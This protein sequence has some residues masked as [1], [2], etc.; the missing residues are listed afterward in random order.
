MD[1]K[2]LAYINMYAV[3]GGLVKLCDMV[4][5]AQK[6]LGKSGASIG[7][8]VKDGPSA[9]FTFVG[10]KCIMKGGVEDCVI[11]I[12]F[13]S[14]EKFNGMIDGKVTPI[15]TKGFTKIGFLLN[16]FTKL[17]DL[18]TR[19]LRPTE[20][21]LRDPVFFEQSTLLM[22]HVIAGAICQIANHDKVGMASAKYITDGV[23]KMEIAGAESVAL[24]AKNH[25]LTYSS[26]VPDRIMSFMQFA[27]IKTARDLFDGKINSVASVGTGG[28]RMGGMISQIDNMNRILSRVELYLR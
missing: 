12:P 8:A 19:Y 7:F 16:K 23:I 24:I 11:K 17:T 13:S 21:D 18:L 22:F 3:L 15:P 14:P 5:E 1:E 28:V 6:I 20:E 25:R 9:T 26:I 27:D 2:T 4:P 10:G